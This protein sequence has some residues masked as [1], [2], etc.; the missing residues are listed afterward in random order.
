MPTVPRLPCVILY[1]YRQKQFARKS[2]E[3][4]KNELRNAGNSRVTCRLTLLD[5]QHQVRVGRQGH[6]DDEKVDTEGECETRHDRKL[7]SNIKKRIMQ[8]KKTTDTFW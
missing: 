4:Y 3:R 8:G 7:L 5:I 1:D 6:G 2:K